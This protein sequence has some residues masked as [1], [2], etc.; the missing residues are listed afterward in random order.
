MEPLYVNIEVKSSKWKEITAST[1]S[2]LIK[3]ESWW[4]DNGPIYILR[5]MLA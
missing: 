4:A 1:A 3:A 2:I 5:K